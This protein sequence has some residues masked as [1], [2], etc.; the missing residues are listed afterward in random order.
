MY[1][2][3]IQEIIIDSL[4]NE[5]FNITNGIVILASQGYLV[6]NCKYNRARNAG[7]LIHCFENIDV[8]TDCQQ[9]RLEDIFNNI[10]RIW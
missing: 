4:G 6:N 7:I 5:I 2:D 10:S 8:L 9:K 3:K 1:D